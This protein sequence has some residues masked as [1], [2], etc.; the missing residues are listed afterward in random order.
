MAIKAIQQRHYLLLYMRAITLVQSFKY[1]AIHVPLTNRWYV[2]YESRF[3]VDNQS[4]QRD[5]RSSEVR[6]NA[7]VVLA[8]AL[9]NML[10]SHY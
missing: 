1:L 3:H 10:W 2:C 5:T 9:N 8:I 4:D 7:T 6:L